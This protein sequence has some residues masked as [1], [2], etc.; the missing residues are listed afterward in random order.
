MSLGDYVT[1]GGGGG[2]QEKFWRREV[3]YYC[4][5]TNTVAPDVSSSES[6]GRRTTPIDA[7]NRDATEGPFHGSAQPAKTLYSVGSL[8]ESSY[9][10][11]YS[12]RIAQSSLEVAT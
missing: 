1:E 11:P 2:G 3:L 8:G 5:C 4:G 10:R 6:P 7:A 12:L 9:V